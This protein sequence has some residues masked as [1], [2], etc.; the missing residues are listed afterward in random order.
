VSAALIWCARLTSAV[1]GCALSLALDG[2]ASAAWLAGMGLK[3]PFVD[4]TLDVSEGLQSVG[5]DAELERRQQTERAAKAALV[6][7]NQGAHELFLSSA[8]LPY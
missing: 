6:E 4:A 8:V 2:A 1:G 7:K 3:P 5:H